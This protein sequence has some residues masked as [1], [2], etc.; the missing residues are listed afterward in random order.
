MA[1]KDK[2]KVPVEL[3]VSFDQGILDQSRTMSLHVRLAMLLIPVSQHRA[4]LIKH[5]ILYKVTVQPVLDYAFPVLCIQ[6]TRNSPVD[7]KPSTK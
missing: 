6:T 5:D 2:E 7:N 1:L 4:Y 3:V